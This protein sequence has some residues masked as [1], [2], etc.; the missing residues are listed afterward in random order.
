MLDEILNQYGNGDDLNFISYYAD[1]PDPF[2]I[3]KAEFIILF[4]EIQKLADNLFYF[5][6]MDKGYSN[7]YC[8]V[9]ISD[10][11]LSAFMIHNYG[12]YIENE[13]VIRL[14]SDYIESYCNVGGEYVVTKSD[15]SLEIK[16]FFT[17]YNV[18][19]DWLDPMNDYCF[20]D[21][22]PDEADMEPYSNVLPENRMFP[23][24]PKR[25]RLSIH[26]NW[27]K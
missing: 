21:V 13:E 22:K 4:N 16:P 24:A 23:N 9:K 10:N 14:F 2:K 6:I 17:Y 20:S 15:M 8:F 3:S 12:G 11:E 26:K 5:K 1:R 7:E 18:R 25:E 19:F 27:R